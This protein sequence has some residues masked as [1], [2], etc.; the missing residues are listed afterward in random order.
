[1]CVQVKHPPSLLGA[2]AD[3]EQVLQTVVIFIVVAHSAIALETANV[4]NKKGLPVFPA[5][6]KGLLFGS[7]GLVETLQEEPVEA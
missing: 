6:I 2:A 3:V 7:L 1:M 4:A 5:L